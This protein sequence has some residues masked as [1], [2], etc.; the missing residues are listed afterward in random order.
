MRFSEIFD[1]TAGVY[2]FF[3]ISSTVRGVACVQLYRGSVFFACS[4]SEGDW[5]CRL[6][7][8]LNSVI[9]FT[10]LPVAYLGYGITHPVGNYIFVM[11]VCLFVCWMF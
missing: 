8:H 11:F 6:Q 3:I 2:I 4:F 9:C 10:V 7:H 5:V 1:L